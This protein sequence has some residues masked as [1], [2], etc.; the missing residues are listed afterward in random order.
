MDIIRILYYKLNRIILNLFFNQIYIGKNAKIKN[1]G[2]IKGPCKIGKNSYVDG[3][4]EAYTYIGEN[5][6]LNANIGK[7]C[8]IANNVKVIDAFHPLNWVS[9]SPVFY[10]NGK[11]CGESFV[12]KKKI[13]DK[14]YIEKNNTIACSIGNDVW[15]GEDV[16]IKG[17]I[18]IGN[19]A[20]IAM[21]AVV[22]KDVPD[23]AVVGGVPAKLIKYRFSDE[24][25]KMLLEFKWW[26]KNSVWLKEHV[27]SFESID[28][29]RNEEF[30]K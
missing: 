13:E 3:S 4:V 11:Q 25:I 9:M 16:L 29:F 24:D 26:E 21:G 23:Y 17:G 27:N 19:G 8:S 28:I 7:F 10:S 18:K 20:C 22:T 15:I 14:L 2:L 1:I 5:C 30:K 12:N 6:K